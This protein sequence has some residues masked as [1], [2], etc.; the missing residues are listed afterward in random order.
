MKFV[1]NT[2][3]YISDTEK[4]KNKVCLLMKFV[5][6]TLI[7]I[8]DTEKR[9]TK[10]CLLVKFVGNKL[11]YISVYSQYTLFIAYTHL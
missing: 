8:S 3:I 6:N 11:I 10:V 2:L 9:K 4:R 7:Y 5:G 1:G